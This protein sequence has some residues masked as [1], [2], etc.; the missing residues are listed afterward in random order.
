MILL[1]LFIFLLAYAVGVITLFLEFVCYKRKIEF[2]ETIYFTISFFLFLIALSISNVFDLIYHT[3]SV[4]SNPLVSISMILLG[5]TTPLNIFVERKVNVSIF[6]KNGL[7]M[8]ASA[9]FILVIVDLIFKNLFFI[10][11]VIHFYLVTSVVFSMLIIRYSKPEHRIEHLEKIEKR[12]AIVILII[13]PITLF[14]DFFMKN[15]HFMSALKFEINITVPSLFIILATSKFFDNLSRLSLFKSNNSI[16][17]Q[18]ADNY[19]LTKR[20]REIAE[21]LIKGHSYSEISES[22]FISMPTVKSHVTNIYKKT[23]VSNKMQLF[24]ALTI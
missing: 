9:L 10:D 21:M 4:E 19:N 13:M 15:S 7:V 14:I 8:L 17:Q 16:Q 24:N 1:Q 2:I 22:L 23:E 3:K 20:E 11:T 6:I 18:N 5:L 12:M